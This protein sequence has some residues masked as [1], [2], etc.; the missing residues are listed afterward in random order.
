[1]SDR[2]IFL[3]VDGIGLGEDDPEINPLVKFGFSSLE[4][5]FGPLIGGFGDFKEVDG[6]ILISGD[7]HLGV[8]GTP[9]SA[10]GTASL[11]T[12]IN[13]QKRFERHK[14][15]LPDREIKKIIKAENIYA[16]LSGLDKTSTFINAYKHPV[17]SKLLRFRAST[18]TVAAIYGIGSLRGLGH[19]KMG[20]AVY[21]DID[22]TTLYSRRY[23]VE[24]IT[25]EEA[26]YNLL[27]VSEDFHLTVFEFFLTDVAGHKQDMGMATVVLEKLDAFID[28]ILDNLPSETLFILSS[29]HGNLEN[30]STKYHTNNDVP[31]ILIC[32]DEEFLKG[33]RHR[34][35][36][37]E[38][39]G[40]IESYLTS[41]I[42]EK[43]HT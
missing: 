2:V 26:G 37:D 40:I 1:M 9:Q 42:I 27:S 23:G 3:F 8:P 35:G 43:E 33:C 25:P 13:V 17:I 19:L 31:I 21:H 6:G 15:G 32:E 7:C 39:A 20:R 16:R 36:I 10:T 12:G 34:M 18:T 38:V 5:Y 24:T 22:N 41:K 29:D 28:T 14:H 11:F 4:E 30:L